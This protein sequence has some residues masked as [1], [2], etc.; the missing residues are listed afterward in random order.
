MKDNSE[1]NYGRI[2]TLG[3]IKVEKERLRRKIAKQE[4]ILA[5]DWENISYGWRFVDKILGA[6]NSLF[7][8]VFV[9]S[10]I[11]LVG[12]LMSYLFSKKKKQKKT[13]Q[14]G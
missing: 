7:S 2:S 14:A 6:A 1:R 11:E 9:S 5:E 13:V 4:K 12:K 3:E 10:G 8:S